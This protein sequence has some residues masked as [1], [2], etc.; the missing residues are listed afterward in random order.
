MTSKTLHVRLSDAEIRRQAVG[1]VVTLRD[2]RHPA[3]RFRFHQNR[4]RGSWHVVVRGVWGKAGNYPDL[5]ASAML[6]ALPVILKRR[7]EDQVA[8][9]TVSSWTTVGDLLAWYLDRMQRDRNLSTKRKASARSAIQRHLLPRLRDLALADVARTELDRRLIW[10]LQER[11]AVAFVRQVYGV[12][13]VAFRRALELEM[14]AS[15]PM[16]GMT[17]TTFVKAKIRPK[18]ARLRGAQVDDL[19]V[20]LIER[21]QVAPPEGLLALLMLCHGTRLGETR[22]T[23]WGNLTLA[24]EA[25]KWYLP[26]AD[27][28]TRREHRLPLTPQAIAL[29]VRY[30]DW[31]RRQGYSGAFLFPGQGN[32]PI[33]AAQATTIFNSLGQGEWSSH[34]LRKLAR[35][36]W[37]DLGIDY[38]IG[39]LLVNHALR[40]LDATYIHTTASDGK[41]LALAK[42]HDWL[43]D[44]G[45]DLV[46]G[47]IKPRPD[48]E[49]NPCPPSES[50]A[51]AANQVP[52]QWRNQ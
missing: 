12:L 10:P 6:E 1:Q 52:T 39:E 14:I 51:C 33:S 46:H 22:V 41:R 36:C 19:L 49:P 34:D 11:Y 21:Y 18:P 4:A 35:T 7:A 32:R 24:G 13:A 2:P 44:H 5:S 23:K 37:T 3:L 47:W 31:Q 50:A 30:R 8:R 25:P 28:K 16:A 27:T 29:L 26:P 40:D 42:W 15:N 9:S 48:N 17:F 43:D 45:F 20:A 38:L